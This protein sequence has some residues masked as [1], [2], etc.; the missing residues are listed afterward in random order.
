MGLAGRTRRL[1]RH[2]RCRLRPA[3]RLPAPDDPLLRRAS[4]GFVQAR[5]GHLDEGDSLFTRLQAMAID[6]HF[7]VEQS[8]RSAAGYFTNFTGTAGSGGDGD[9]GRRRLEQRGR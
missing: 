7:L 9:R 2:L 3:A 8:V 6:F 1:D 5:W 4:I